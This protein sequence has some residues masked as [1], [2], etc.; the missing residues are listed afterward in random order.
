M[1]PP[2]DAMRIVPNP[3]V[4]TLYVFPN[5]RDG[6]LRAFQA[7]QSGQTIG[8]SGWSLEG[9]WANEDTD[10]MARTIQGDSRIDVTTL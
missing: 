5:T 4:P 7:S 1:W 6:F 8:G 9:V 3:A 10:Q 2:F